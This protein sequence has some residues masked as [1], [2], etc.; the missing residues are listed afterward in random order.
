MPPFMGPQAVWFLLL[1][2]LATVVSP[3]AR[4]QDA[5]L[6]KQVFT[7]G[8]TPSCGLCHTL[9]A[10]GSSGEIGPNL[11]ELKP[12]EERVRRAVERGVGNMPAFGE[13]LSDQ[14]IAAVSQFVA[15]AV[16]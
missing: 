9:A 16:R 6:G 5:E 14:Q 4:A 3:G 1:W 2:L 8:T 12:P 10:A 13:S 7:S 11:D 15:N